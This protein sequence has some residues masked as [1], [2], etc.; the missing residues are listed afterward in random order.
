MRAPVS[1]SAHGPRLTHTRRGGHRYNVTK[2]RHLRNAA[3]GT[4]H[5]ALR[6]P[7]ALRGRRL[8]HEPIPNLCMFVGTNRVVTRAVVGPVPG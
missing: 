5:A 7:S 3:A 1:V 2:V 6:T 8:D 4:A